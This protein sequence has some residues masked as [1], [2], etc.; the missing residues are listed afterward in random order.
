MAQ[1][2]TKKDLFAD[3]RELAED[4][5]RADLIEFIDHE[6]ELLSKKASSK[7]PTANQKANEEIK[8]AILETLKVIGEPVTISEMSLKS[9]KLNY[10]PQKLSALLSQLEADNLVVRSKDKKRTLFTLA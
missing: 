5:E 2:I 8:E 1:K 4:A 9:P 7:K 10:T 6:I 3:L